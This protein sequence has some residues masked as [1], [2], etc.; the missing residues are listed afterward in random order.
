MRIESAL[1]LVA[2]LAALAPSALARGGNEDTCGGDAVWVEN[3]GYL[4]CLDYQ[5]E[6][7][8]K[9]MTQDE[10]DQAMG[11]PWREAAETKVRRVLHS[12][13]KL[14][15]GLGNAALATF[16]EF[17]QVVQHVSGAL[18][19]VDDADLEDELAPGEKLVQAATWKLDDANRITAWLVNESVWTQMDNIDRAGLM[20]H[21]VL[22]VTHA[23]AVRE[24]GG[25]GYDRRA[26]RR[27]VA[28]ISTPWLR[29]ATVDDFQDFRRQTALFPGLD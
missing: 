18:K 16:D 5:W 17:Q 24:T 4:F 10:L 29:T 9:R 25:R 11:D 27:F 7:E 15:P 26:L 12:V 22:Y 23:R 14:D 2:G 20:L 1:L 6:I 8:Q 28:R 13:A 21:E 3:G 19:E